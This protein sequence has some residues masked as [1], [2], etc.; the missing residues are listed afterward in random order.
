MKICYDH[1]IFTTQKAGGISRYFK[2][3]IDGIHDREKDESI[4]AALYSDNIYLE[5]NDL[6]STIGRFKF[7]FN[8]QKKILKRN[9]SYS[10][11][12]IKN[13]D[14][15]IF[16]PTYFDP[17]YLPFIKKPTVITVH[18]MTYE[19]LPHL[20][21]ANDPTP[22]NKRLVME[23]AEKLIAISEKTKADILKFTN[24]PEQKIEVI[25]HGI[26]LTPPVY[27]E[28]DGLPNEY[29]LYVGGRWS[30]KN[31]FLLIDAFEQIGKK[32]P[33][34]F[35]VLAGGGDMAYGDSEYLHRKKLQHRVKHVNPTDAQLN[36]LYK[37]AKCFVYPSS[38]EGFGFPI[39]EAFSNGCPALLSNIDCF[40]E[41]A[42]KGANYF[43]QGSMESLVAEINKII[44]SKAVAETLIASGKLKLL[45]Y[46]I[47]NCVSKTLDVYHSMH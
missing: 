9:Q 26:D 44:E 41:I 25:H 6:P 7:L 39:L 21:P 38:Y 29:I 42:G 12:I 24:I 10:K 35:L 16:H 18:D 22:Y 33:N 46:N 32:H 13:G 14:F 27:D 28:I 43:E 47:E 11:K 3:L 2:Y 40:K 37:K 4:L 1:Q 15:D 31:F 23:K 36:T 30:Y 20:F 45:T 17:Y 8:S 5:K 19:A 34:L